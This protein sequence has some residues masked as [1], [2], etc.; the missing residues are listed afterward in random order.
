MLIR[1][2]FGSTPAPK[3]ETGKGLTGVEIAVECELAHNYGPVMAVSWIERS[4]PP[5]GCCTF[6]GPDAFPALGPFLSHSN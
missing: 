6:G 5:P 4:D 1:L 3:R 2:L